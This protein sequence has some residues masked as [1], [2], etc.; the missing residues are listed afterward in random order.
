LGE[1]QARTFGEAQIDLDLIFDEGECGVIGNAMLKSRSSDSFT[2]QLKDFIR[3]ETVDIQNCANVI[4]RKQTDPDGSTA[5]FNFD[6][7]FATDPATDASFNLTDDGVQD[8]GGLVLFGED[9]T[10]TEDL[11]ALPAGWAF[12]NVDCSASTGVTPVIGPDGALV[13]FDLD[14]PDDVLDCTYN[15]QARGT[16]VVEKITDDGFGSFDFTSN[17]LTP[18]S[19]TLTTTAAGDAG[20]DSRTFGDLP[21][22]TY[23][24]AE[25]VP[26]GWNL[27]SASCDDGSDPSSIGLDAGETVTCTFHDSRERGA[28]E[29]TKTRKHAAAGSATAPHEGVTFTVTG[30]E[31][32]SGMTVV[33]D[34][35]GAAC[36]DGLVL[37]SFVGDYTV[38]ETVPDGY[39]ADGA[40]AKTVSVTTEASCGDGNEA[41]V[42]FSNT[43]LTNVTVSVD[44]QVDGGTASTI[45]CVNAADEELGA[46]ETGANGDGSVTVEDLEPTAPG[47]TLICTIVVDP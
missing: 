38:T 17:T 4:I 10:V 34:A 25:T 5:E 41:G 24:V 37:S 11:T 1:K 19:F 7:T 13:T 47:D 45:S 44:S 12:T 6:K 8:Y 35:N 23:D 40:T 22:G 3:P 31:L 27:V 29:I 39:V 28:I 33:T 36:V 46:G 30:G 32:S 42:S 21:T 16:I 18:A 14:D 20:K 43:P 9:L 15:N 26:A 2:S